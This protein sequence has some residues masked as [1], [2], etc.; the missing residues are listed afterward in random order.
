[1]VR[2]SLL[3]AAIGMHQRKRCSLEPVKLVMQAYRVRWSSR[4]SG[5]GLHQILYEQGTL[6]E[7][8][9]FLGRQGVPESVTTVTAFPCVSIDTLSL[10]YLKVRNA[11]HGHVD[12]QP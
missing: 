7:N 5:Q 11:M 8:D 3:C 4:E 10:R 9:M 2:I 1:M 6:T 12:K